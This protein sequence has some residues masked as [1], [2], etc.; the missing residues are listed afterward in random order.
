MMFTKL[1]QQ[2]IDRLCCPLCKAPIA[3][4][5]PQA[6]SFLCRACNTKYPRVTVSHTN[7]EE[8][9]YDFR[10]HRPAYSVPVGVA[11]WS[12]T[13]AEYEDSCH[14]ERGRTDVLATYLKEIDSVREIYRV[15]FP[16]IRGSV[17]DLGGYQ[18]T[19][20]YY[21]LP[22]NVP[23]YVCVDPLL[24]AFRGLESQPN[25]LKAY[26]SLSEPCNFLS[27]HAEHLPFAANSFDWVHMRSVLDHF[28]DP[29][30]AIKETY[31]VLK[32][33]GAI[34]IGLT[35]YGGQS[36]LKAPDEGWSSPAHWSGL[37]ARIFTKVRMDGMSGLLKTAAS[38]LKRRQF[39]GARDEHTF[40]WKYD[41]LL[42]LL[43]TTHFS[44]AKEHWQKPPFT[45]CVYVLARRD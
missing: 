35:V 27:C 31:R 42:D 37:V 19:L 18:G 20:R 7:H 17:L 6:D 34:L 32:P 2:V 39:P 30:L 45:M 44:V 16:D 15:E 23:L 33:G 24:D 1:D 29:F 26:P 10:V 36:S 28:E 9:V 13:Q 40:Q 38:T 8:Y 25:L 3:G 41:D 14:G 21:L 43:S 11:R 5:D 22:A 12:L 4:H